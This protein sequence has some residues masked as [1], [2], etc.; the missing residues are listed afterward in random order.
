[1]TYLQRAGGVDDGVRS[2]GHI[3]RHNDFGRALQRRRS[4]QSADDGVNV[5]M[6]E[7]QQRRE[8]MFWRRNDLQDSRK[9]LD[10]AQGDGEARCFRR[11]QPSLHV[12]VALF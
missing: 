1:M 12:P 8:P 10:V 5:R 6:N 3:G 11:R 4:A 7:M 2:V 9:E